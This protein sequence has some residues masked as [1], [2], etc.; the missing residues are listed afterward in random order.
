MNNQLS[1]IVKEKIRKDFSDS[2]QKEIFDEFEK[3]YDYFHEDETDDFLE[4]DEIESIYLGILK[5]S[6]GK[7]SHFHD[8]V[9]EAKSDWRNILYWNELVVND[10]KT[11]GVSRIKE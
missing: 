1:E 2:E 9:K 7:M 6:D 3:L 5:L 4:S 10:S 8:A 11:G